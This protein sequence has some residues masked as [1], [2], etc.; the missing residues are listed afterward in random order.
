M[1]SFE[2]LL[3]QI[4]AFIRKYYKNQMLK[5]LILF[6]GIC[7]FT[8]L[9]VI[10]LEY[11][12]RFSSLIRGI[13]FFSFISVNLFILGKYILLPLSK[14]YSFGKRINRFQAAN[15]IGTFFPNISDRL[16]NT[17]QLNESLLNNDSSYELIRASVNQRS[18]TLSAFSFV[19][20][21]DL[22]KNYVYVRYVLPL[23]FIFSSL[24]IFYP[25][26]ISQGTKRVVN[27]TKEFKP[28]A[29]FDFV[30]K[31]TNFEIEEGN[32]FPIELKVKGNSLPEKIY[33]H[34]SSGKFLMNKTSKISS[35]FVLKRLKEDVSFYFEANG[36]QSKRY[37]LLVIPKSAIGKFQA[38]LTY[39]DYLGKKNE[40]ISNAGDLVIP[41]GTKVTWSVATKNTIKTKLSWKDT[42]FVSSK[43]GFNFSKR[44][45]SSTPMSVVLFNSK[46]QIKD[47]LN[48][49]IEIVP[50]QYPTIDVNEEID[51]ISDAL[52]FFEGQISDDYGLSS[53]YFVYEIVSKNGK[54][55]T[56]KVSVLNPSGNSQPFRHAVDFRREKLAVDDKIEYYFLVKDNDGVHG[57]KASRSKT[58]VYELPSLSELNE[59][60]DEDQSNAKDQLKDLIKKSAEFK[61]DIQQLKKE[62]LNS[63]STDWNQMNQVQ[64]LKEERNALQNELEQLEMKMQESLMEKN[65][66]SEMDQEL[67]DKQELL[68]ELLE[69]VMDDEL[70]DLLNKL[71][72]MM[73]NQD[74]NNLEKNLENLDMKSEDMNKQLD[75]S[76]EMLKKMQVN[77]KIDDAVKELKDLSKEQE[78]LKEDIAN[79]KLSKEDGEKKQDDINKKFD[80]IKED[81]NELKKLNE[82]L[83]KP[84]NL[85]DQEEMKKEIS[86]ELNQ[87]KENLSESKEKKA[88]QN[89]EKSAKKME[90]MAQELEQMQQ[91]SNKK[92]E[93]EDMD[94]L[95][96]ILESLMTLSFTQEDIMNRFAKV[97][98][99]DPYYTKLGKAQRGII[100]DTKI[101]ED[102]LNAI[103]TRQPKIA[104]F[105]NKELNDINLNFKQGLENVD[106]HRKR[107]LANNLQYVMTGYNNLALMLNESLEQMQQ[108]MK[109]QM[110]GSG[111]CDKP[112]GKGSKPSDGEEGDMKEQLKKQLEKMQKGQKPG[113]EKPGGNKPG[114]SSQGQGDGQNML[115][116]GNKEIAKMAAQQTAIRQRLEQMRN[117]MNKEGKGK[118]NQLNPLINELEKQEKDLINKNFSNEM[119][120]RQKDILTR[121]LE[122]EKALMERGFEEKRESKVG[123]NVFLSNQKRIDEYNN[124][125]LKQIELLRSVD[126]IFRQ[127]YK[128]KANDYFNFVN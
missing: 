60:R 51:S 125:K 36:F 58:F 112:G 87:A 113:G 26:I 124:Q 32:D 61:K 68:Q 38:S 57:A 120:K 52:R 6:V 12:G 117:E 66:L 10:S 30:L 35:F 45:F 111:S 85:G 21:I 104:S 59:K 28:E 119:V 89:Q 70:K 127:Y 110:P 5:G 37:T 102:S 75:R 48:Y 79:D 11:F 81:L 18:K 49:A 123:K 116:L 95:R 107:E 67:L 80:E 19:N 24:V 118:G 115:G 41:E 94:L 84:M 91:E 86:D 27:Y 15:I 1:N 16:L 82:D 105:I 69:E 4:D 71:E 101:V 33:L 7:L 88:S 74:K 14:I 54:K 72:E 25:K 23:V 96:N 56:Q 99:K 3:E 62:V 83:K 8:F 42:S 114:G 128:N 98:D 92:Q 97:K 47:S 31:N 40:V 65:Q 73:K 93:E 50:D 109:S 9:A 121:L 29:P 22:K 63:K 39:P 2:N 122:S 103:A 90:Q 34:S 20:G 64:Q 126:P 17:L 13:L 55:S 77:E 76:L 44:F 53:L 106:E 43:Q 108:Q 78:K 100:D 46:K